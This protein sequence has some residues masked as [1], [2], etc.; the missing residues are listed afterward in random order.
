MSLA[1]LGRMLANDEVVRTH[2]LENGNIFRWPSPKTCGVVSKASMELNEHV[3]TLVVDFWC[4][5]WTR[6]K[7]IPVLEAKCQVRLLKSLY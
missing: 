2:L 3:L 5:Q 1:G 7:T 6:P 4:S